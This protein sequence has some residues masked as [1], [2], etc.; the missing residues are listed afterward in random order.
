MSRRKIAGVLLCV[1]PFC[2]TAGAELIPNAGFDIVGPLGT[3]VMYTLPSPGGPSAALDWNQFMGGTPGSSATTALLPSTDSLPGGGGMMLEFSTN[4]GFYRSSGNGVFANL[5]QFLPT[6]ST[7]SLDINV[8]AG[9]APTTGEIGFVDSGGFS[10]G[11][12][13]FGPTN[14]WLRVTFQNG[15]NRLA[16]EIGFEIFSDGGLLFVDNATASVPEPSS[17]A[18]VCMSLGVLIAMVRFSRRV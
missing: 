18:V 10:Q 1:L 6:G 12:Y 7:G 3:P 5:T 2:T 14:G 4:G 16:S 11:S 17:L 13:L 15:T 8:P 9:R